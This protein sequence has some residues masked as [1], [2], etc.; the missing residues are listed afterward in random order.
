MKNK[1]Q[2]VI[3]I[4]CLDGKVHH[5]RL[6]KRVIYHKA[7]P[8]TQGTGDYIR[9]MGGLRSIQK[10]ALF[11]APYYEVNARTIRSL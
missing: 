1:K 9:Y 5:V 3:C 2:L 4:S 11:M 7:V 8:T 6:E 10:T